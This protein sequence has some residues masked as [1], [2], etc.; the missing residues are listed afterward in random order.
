M[1]T[2][3][4]NPQGGPGMDFEAMA[5]EYLALLLAGGRREATAMVMQALDAGA[6][7]RRI[8]MDVF[9]H[10]LHKVGT[11][12]M[13]NEITVAQEHYCTASIQSAMALM[14][15][16]LFQGERKGLTAV[17]A[18]VGG[19]L[20]EL[21]VRMVADF[22]EM[23]GWDTYYLGASTPDKDVV[24]ALLDR[25]A[26]LLAV[27]V[28]MPYNVHLV[29]RLIAAVRAEPGLAGLKIMAG[30]YPFAIDKDLFREVG[31]DATASSAE[32]VIL[33]V[34]GLLS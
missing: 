18:C 22:L 24:A 7:I 5:D 23:E 14:Y 33:V 21:G 32:E 16:R 11:L 15:P 19:E 20:H 9:Q 17:A 29:K 26:D 12:W 8:Y 31:A 27:S 30:G 25:K 2:G 1:A 3:I 4:E 10:A 6:D 13:R 28:T 34:G